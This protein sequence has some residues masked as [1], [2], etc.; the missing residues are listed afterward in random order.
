MSIR[1]PYGWVHQGAVTLHPTQH[2]SVHNLM[3]TYFEQLRSH[4]VQLLCWSATGHISQ[5]DLFLASLF[6]CE[7]SYRCLLR[8]TGVESGL[9]VL[10]MLR[11]CWE[12]IHQ[13]GQVEEDHFIQHVFFPFLVE[14]Q[15]IRLQIKP[16]VQLATS[17]LNR[18]MRR[19]PRAYS[20]ICRILTHK[21]LW[22]L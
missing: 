6:S 10:S 19:L 12:A 15:T 3:D 8:M 1:T 5:P 16:A 4:M 2:E 20:P 22:W 9:N 18:R 7:Q 21:V 17:L 14:L 13:R 11:Q